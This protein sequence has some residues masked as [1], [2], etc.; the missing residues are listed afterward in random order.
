ML[1]AESIPGGHSA[2]SLQHS[3]DSS[4]CQFDVLGILDQPELAAHAILDRLG[5]GRVV[6]HELLDVL[7]TLTE[8]F[9]AEGEPRSALLDNLSID[10]Q[11]QQVAF[12]GDPLTVHDV[13][14][15]FA[16]RWG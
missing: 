1:N 6:L 7:A 16:E 15:G 9:T 4:A 13:E 14:L 11:I 2:F 12:L 3:L 8:A 5:D 10:G